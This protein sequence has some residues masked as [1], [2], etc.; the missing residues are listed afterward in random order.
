MEF[1]RDE[2]ILA[3]EGKLNDELLTVYHLPFTYFLL[4]V[5]VDY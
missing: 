2:K 4:P 3:R 1:T 5:L